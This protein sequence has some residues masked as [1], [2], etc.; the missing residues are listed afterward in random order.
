MNTQF[1]PQQFE[2]IN[3]YDL[4]KKYI[5]SYN[6][7][8]EI[9]DEFGIKVP[10]FLNKNLNYH[11]ESYKGFIYRYDRW[12]NIKNPS[13]D[14]NLVVESKDKITNSNPLSKY[15]RYNK[16]GAELCHAY[17]CR[18]HTKLV[19]A[20]RGLFCKNHYEELVIIRN[21]LNNAKLTNNKIKEVEFR[22][23][24]FLMRKFLDCG[25]MKF[26]YKVESYVENKIE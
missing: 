14:V 16:N 10:K 26:M 18:K 17:K 22:Q 23:K 6:S 25:H 8:K 21:E 5:K 2:K 9:L 3:M 19:N 7:K 24:E 13:L 4:D 20:F 15:D 12:D 1:N 11:S